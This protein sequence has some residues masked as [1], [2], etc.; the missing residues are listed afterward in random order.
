MAFVCTVQAELGGREEGTTFPVDLNG[1]D[2]FYLR[3]GKRPSRSY[4]VKGRIQERSYIDVSLF[5]R[6]V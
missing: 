2:N 1:R 4:H 5:T 3:A 6:L